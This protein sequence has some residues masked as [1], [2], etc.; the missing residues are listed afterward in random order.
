MLDDWMPSVIYRGAGYQ[1]QVLNTV[2]IIYRTNLWN[3]VDDL[4]ISADNAQNVDNE[5]MGRSIDT[6]GFSREML[7]QWKEAFIGRLMNGDL[8]DLGEVLEKNGRGQELAY[9][10]LRELRERGGDS[11]KGLMGRVARGLGEE[12]RK[13]RK[14]YKP[15]G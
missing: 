3:F 7:V 2:T 5:R 1:D 15:W 9:E 12:W 6:R 8:S 13:P 11:W 14:W 10:V 4:V